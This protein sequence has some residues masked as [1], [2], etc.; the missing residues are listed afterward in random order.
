LDIYKLAAPDQANAAL[1]RRPSKAHGISVAETDLQPERSR[2]VWS[3]TDEPGCAST[4]MPYSG[5]SWRL[6]YL[7]TPTLRPGSQR[8]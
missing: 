4:F 1:F 5:R 2:A 8:L 6:E 7:A 3:I